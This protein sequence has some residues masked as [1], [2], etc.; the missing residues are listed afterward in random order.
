M[1]DIKVDLMHSI[2]FVKCIMMYPY[3]NNIP[4]I[5]LFSII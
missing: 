1:A 5:T 2:D 3:Y 4:N